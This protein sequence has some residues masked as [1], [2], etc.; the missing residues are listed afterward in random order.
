MPGLLR[1][2]ARANPELA[3]FLT[4]SCQPR[5]AKRQLGSCFIINA[6]VGSLNPQ[7]REH[8]RPSALFA[9]RLSRPLRPDSETSH[10]R[11]IFCFLP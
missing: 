1:W 3:L 8:R 2:R 5:Q 9:N 7:N 11:S 6:L 4:P 10:K